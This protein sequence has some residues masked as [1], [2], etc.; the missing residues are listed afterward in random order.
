VDHLFFSPFLIYMLFWLTFPLPISM[1]AYDINRAA[2]KNT[3]QPRE[4]LAEEG[5]RSLSDS[6]LVALLFGT[7]WGNKSV[8]SLSKE[9]LTF[10]EKKDFNFTRD[11]LE[12]IKGMG[13]AKSSQIMAVFEMVRRHSWGN[14]LKITTPELVQRV[15]FHYTDRPNEYFFALTLNG[16]HELIKTHIIST[17]NLNRVYVQPREVFVEAIRDRAAAIMVAHN[18]PSG[19]LEP[20]SEDMKMTS[21]LKEA[22][23]MLNI[24]LLDH[25]IFSGEGYYSFLENRQI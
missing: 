13:R 20:S 10:I 14:K 18:H 9:V 22:S 12:L 24:P 5:V 3:G 4:R 8:M 17:G 16:A 2:G 25:V 15:L 6:D 1:M 23:Q 11:D 21:T 7:G 19:S